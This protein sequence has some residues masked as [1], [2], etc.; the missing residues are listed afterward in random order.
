MFIRPTLSSIFLLSCPNHMIYYFHLTSL[1]YSL[2]YHLQGGQP[3]SV[4][5]PF[6]WWTAVCYHDVIFLLLRQVLLSTVPNVSWL[7]RLPTSLLLP[8]MTRQWRFLT[9]LHMLSTQTILQ[10]T[11]FW[12]LPMQWMLTLSMILPV[13]DVHSS[14]TFL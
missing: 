13:G 14:A 7:G 3:T 1:F 6:R 2:M 5:V 9:F 4:I 8:F 10:T 12:L 11:D